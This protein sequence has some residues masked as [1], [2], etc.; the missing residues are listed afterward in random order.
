[1]NE[2]IGDLSRLALRFLLLKRVD[3]ATLEVRKPLLRVAD[4]AWRARLGQPSPF[5]FFFQPFMQ[6]IDSQDEYFIADPL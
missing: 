4:Q 2:P 5:P 3:P 1:M 6:I